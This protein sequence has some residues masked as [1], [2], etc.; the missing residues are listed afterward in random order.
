MLVFRGVF[1]KSGDIPA[2]RLPKDEFLQLQGTRGGD[3]AV[4]LEA[5]Q[6]TS[7]PGK[8]RGKKKRG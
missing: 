8:R 5:N 6:F 2:S 7:M 1:P 4:M 3:V